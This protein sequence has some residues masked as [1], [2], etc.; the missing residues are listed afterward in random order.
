MR[1]LIGLL[2]CAGLLVVCS[3][4]HARDHHPTAKPPA[5]EA[6]EVLE[7]I[8]QS[9]RA[10]A[11]Q[12][13]GEAVRLLS[14]ELGRDED[15]NHPARGELL[16]W[17][18]LAYKGQGEYGKARKTFAEA[19][20][21]RDAHG[22]CLDVACIEL[23]HELGNVAMSDGE[24]G[25]SLA[26]LERAVTISSA[27]Q[28][29]D[30]EARLASWLLLGGAHLARNEPHR[31]EVALRKAIEVAERRKT[32]ADDDL[33]SALFNLAEVLRR[34]GRSEEAAELVER[35]MKLSPPKDGPRR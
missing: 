5:P 14:E 20:D 35:G 31:A 19:L 10:L 15:R 21:M 22:G 13:A 29:D 3:P 28:G 9:R 27:I 6:G 24:P 7:I 16:R 17:L 34:T 11:E 4:I 2:L 30:G 26:Y 32:T 12:D 23:L 8:E 25:A 18:G 33:Q 1:P